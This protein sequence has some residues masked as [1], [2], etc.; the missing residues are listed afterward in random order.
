K[1]LSD[2]HRR[3]AELEKS[4]YERD[5]VEG[6]VR[7]NE[8][9][10]RN[11]VENAHDVIWVF[12]LNLGY[13]Y[14]SPSIKRLR[15]YTVE[16]AMKQRLDQV[17]TPESARE[18]R[19]LFERERDLEISGHHHGPDWSFTTELEIIRKNG[20]TLW[21]EMTMNPVY[22]EAGRIK[23]I[24]GITR[25]ISERKRAEEEL[26]KHNDQLEELVKERTLE[27]REANAQLKKEIAERKEV[28][29]KLRESEEK[30]RVYFSLSNDVM[31]SYDNRFRVQSVSPNVEKNLGY[32]PEE[33]VGKTFQDVN[34]LHPDC[35][36]EAITNALK[37][38]SGET[39]Y[40]SVY[41]FITKEGSRK[42]GEVSG[43]PLKRNN[44]V[45][46][47]ITVA[48]DITDR[49][50]MQRSLKESEERYR[51]T[52]QSMPDAVSIM[53]IDDSR[54]IY[55]NG[56]FCKIT[57]YTLEEAIG[58]TPFDLNLPATSEALD[59]CRELLKNNE[60][61]DSMEH[62]C[63]KK[64]GNIIDTIVST[65]P[66]FYGG[67]DCMVMVMTDIT[68]LKRIEEEK[69][70]LDIKSNKMEAIGTLASGIAHDFNNILTS[71]L[72]Y[73]KMSMQ[74]FMA[75]KKEDKDLSVVRSDL[76]E[77]R[78]A[79]YRARDLVNHILAFSR[80]SEKDYSPITLGSTIKESLKLLKPSL[81]ANIKIHEDLTDSHLILGDPAQIHLVLTNLCTNA[82]YAMDKTGG[83]LDV[84]IKPVLVDEE[85]SL[86]LDV[87]AGAYV[88]LTVRDTG[89]GMS[90]KVMA[91]IFDPYFTTKWKGH[92]TGLG[93]SIVLGI[94][95]SHGGAINCKS[96]PG[97]G[98]TFD[99]YLPRHEAEGESCSEQPETAHADRDMIILNLDEDLHHT[100]P[101]K[102]IDD[103][104]IHG[105][106]RK[107]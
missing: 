91:R 67:E 24:M 77:V 14:I 88:K 48:R 4:L 76:N 15:G 16:E 56:A 105:K 20:S 51:I 103:K 106:E 99:I 46:G 73:T 84:S 69:K 78:N 68:A 65:R 33:L 40:S 2:A 50:A 49:I 7:G 79:A 70:R 63:L 98:T 21:V 13:T 83:E 34:V 37:V 101:R 54:Y 41:E 52:L 25:D 26:R 36:A 61:I 9:R 82:A 80:H 44:Q 28:E 93:L 12:D 17:L 95:K 11:L 62:Q 38:F 35:M 42:F 43:V 22:D 64:D 86:N 19:E 60:P 89:H 100:G 85:S 47:E 32:K 58:K 5:S 39:V 72:G 81:P 96:A 53:S 8:E 71:I 97:Q 31:F 92:G 1:A 102:N 23:N 6:A 94:I 45:V 87:P 30:Y 27:L 3:I 59:Q 75:I 10:Y 90:P 74:D 107:H 104:R 18:A 29:D 55:V 66:V 57:G